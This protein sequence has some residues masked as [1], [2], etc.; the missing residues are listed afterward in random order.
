[1]KCTHHA[2]RCARAAELAEISDRTGK[3]HF[4]AEALDVHFQEVDCRLT[5]LEE[6][7]PCALFATR[8]KG[9]R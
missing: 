9:S 6:S 3:A 4:L 7:P 5:I 1:M 8:T 2:C